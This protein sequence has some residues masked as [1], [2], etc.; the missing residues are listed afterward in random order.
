MGSVRVSSRL[1]FC[2]VVLVAALGFGGSASAG[3]AAAANDGV[4]LRADLTGAQEV[5]PADP[6]GRG[7]A[8]VDINVQGNEVCFDVRF[9][10]ITTANRGHIHSGVAGVNGPIV[11]AFFDLQAAG[12]QDERLDTLEDDSG[13]EGCVAPA[14]GTPP[15]LLADIV[16]NPEN[17]YVNLHNSRFPGG[18]IRCQLEP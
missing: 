6:D 5:P 1:V 12:L 18:A 2:G 7:A 4:R 16:A 11:V 9:K 13:L 14:P 3:S 8:K 15:G 17:Y 10:D